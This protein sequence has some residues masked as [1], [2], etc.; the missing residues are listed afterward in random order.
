MCHS[1]LAKFSTCRIKS[2]HNESKET[3]TRTHPYAV[4]QTC[5]TFRPPLT[6][7]LRMSHHPPSWAGSRG[8]GARLLFL[9][10]QSAHIV[11]FPAAEPLNPCRRQLVK[12]GHASGPLPGY[13]PPLFLLMKHTMRRTK[14]RSAMAHIS[15]MNHP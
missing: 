10:L 2:K 13:F 11:T 12:K 14:M 3:N 8:P 6:C 15:P 7:T 5:L 4:I 9:S 1:C